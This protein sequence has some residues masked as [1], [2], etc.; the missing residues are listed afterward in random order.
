M[1]EKMDWKVIILERL[2]VRNSKESGGFT[3]LVASRKNCRRCFQICLAVVTEPSLCTDGKLQDQ[4]ESLKKEIT[5]L[6]YQKNELE[7][8]SSDI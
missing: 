6:E 5:R 8:V 3:E 1:N 2:R 4:A 7:R